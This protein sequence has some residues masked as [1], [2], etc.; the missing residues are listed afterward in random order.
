MPRLQRLDPV[1]FRLLAR[2][3]LEVEFPTAKFRLFLRH[4]DCGACD[5]TLR[6]SQIGTA[7]EV[8]LSE[9]FRDEAVFLAALYEDGFAARHA[10]IG[11]TI[12]LGMVRRGLAEQL[13]AP[14][15]APTPQ[16]GRP[17]MWP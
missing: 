4:V 7:N 11:E 2:V 3:P 12:L 10:T 9:S 15:K 14:K 17:W 6:A 5:W 16:N 8:Y 1:W 13:A